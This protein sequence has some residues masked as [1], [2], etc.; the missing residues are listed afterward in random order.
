MATKIPADIHTMSDPDKAKC[1][2]ALRRI[3][4]PEKRLHLPT[5]IAMIGE[6]FE[7]EPEKDKSK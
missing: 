5:L 2:L 6:T 4:A 3:L 7:V 1:V